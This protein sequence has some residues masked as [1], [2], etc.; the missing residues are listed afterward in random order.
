MAQPTVDLSTEAAAFVDILKWSE[1][2][3][4]W[5]RDALRSSTARLSSLA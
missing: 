5:Q 3:P 1:G 4:V 2:L